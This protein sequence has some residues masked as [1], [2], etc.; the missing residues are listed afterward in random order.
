M[1]GW[2]NQRNESH[3]IMS[4]PST[5]KRIIINSPPKMKKQF[6]SAVQKAL[7]FWNVLMDMFLVGMI[8]G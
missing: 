3:T 2:R 4:L 6:D 5:L 1:F 8:S 7:P